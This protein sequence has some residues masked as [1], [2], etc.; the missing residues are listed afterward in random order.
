M[1]FWFDPRCW[2][3]KAIPESFENAAAMTDPSLGSEY[4]AVIIP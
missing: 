3:S 4:T 1:E 2:A